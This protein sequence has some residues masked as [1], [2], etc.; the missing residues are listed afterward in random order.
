MVSF[1]TITV[2]AK[3]LEL[4]SGFIATSD[5]VEKLL[6]RLAFSMGIAPS[7]YMV[8]CKELKL[9][10]TTAGT[11]RAIKSKDIS[12]KFLKK[13]F[14][15]KTILERFSSSFS[16]K[17]RLLFRATLPTVIRKT[18][19]RSSE[20][21]KSREWESPITTCAMFHTMYSSIFHRVILMKS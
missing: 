6:V 17:L 1:R 18:V 2:I 4:W 10:L 21:S 8:K 9:S 15:P 3:D 7:V 11:L 16:M 12:T 5:F 19:L 14:S 20:F 13:L